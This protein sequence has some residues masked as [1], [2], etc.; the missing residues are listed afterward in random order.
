M[1]RILTGVV[2]VIL[3]GAL[4]IWLL[5]GNTSWGRIYLPAGAGLTAKQACSMTF[6]SGLEPDLAK[7]A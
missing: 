3:L 5:L 7:T 6:V 1:A 2:G 4:G